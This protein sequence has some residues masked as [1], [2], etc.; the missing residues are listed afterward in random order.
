VAAAGLG[1]RAGLV[2]GA[3]APAELAGIRSIVPGLAFLVPGVGAQG[4]EAADVLVHGAA[5]AEPAGARP[6]G[7][8][9]VN[10]SRGIAGAA[11]GQPSAGSAQDPGER[12]A[13]AAR[14]WAARLPVLR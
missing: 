1:D 9:L 5:T 3:T 11:L 2:V 4:G 14:G 6:G 10:V 7:G 8:L 12:L 13:E